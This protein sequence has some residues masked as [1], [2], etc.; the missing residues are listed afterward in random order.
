MLHRSV[1]R[2]GLAGLAAAAFLVIAGPSVAAAHAELES[3]S[4]A[5]G[6]TVPSPFT[7]PIGMTFSAALANGSKA[8]LI[9]P[10]GT[11][12]AAA[13]VDGPEATMTNELDA[14]LSAGNYEVKWVSVGE[15]TDLE[16]GTFSFTVA[17]TPS[18]ATPS[19]GPTEPSAVP[20]VSDTPA[21]E[22]A[23]PTVTTAASPSQSP[24]GD[25]SGPADVVLPIVVG[26]IVVGGGAVF[27][28]G[29]RNRTPLA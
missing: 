17:P 11:V 15:D 10:D 12:L 22:S 1:P 4:P 24:G 27:L 28:L 13:S 3:S 23:E 18:P 2:R 14:P 16:R 6:A 26:L 5:D 19:P 29:R 8:D 21:T 20:T 25:A 7:G 9:G